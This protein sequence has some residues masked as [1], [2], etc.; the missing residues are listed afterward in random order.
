[1][2]KVILLLSTLILS[3]CSSAI[4]PVSAPTQAPV[5]PTITSLQDTSVPTTPIPSMNTY[6]NPK[7]GYS[8]EYPDLYKVVS[9]SDEYVEFGDKIGIEVMTVDPTS[10]RGD[11]PFIENT[12]DVQLPNYPAKLLT[13]YIGSVG[14]NIP[15]Q[16]K[17]YIIERN[18]FYYVM[19][20]YALGLH[21]SEGDI[22]QIAQLIPEDVVVFDRLA[23]SMQIP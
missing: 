10:P 4:M 1:M 18:G 20:L 14:G 16:F 22:S 5:T 6:N 11:G 19:T 8:V 15:Q 17:R 9:A 3:A 2:K 23:A 21:V 7:Y 13:G 12:M